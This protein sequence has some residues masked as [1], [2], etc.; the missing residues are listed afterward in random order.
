MKTSYASAIDQV[1]D[2]VSIIDR[3]YRYVFVND[4]LARFYDKPREHFL[5]R[6]VVDV[7]GRAH[8]HRSAK[9]KLDRCFA[10]ES[11]RGHIGQVD[12]DGAPRDFE[13]NLEPF[14]D[15]SGEIIGAISV[16]RDVTE[17]KKRHEELQL[18]RSAIDQI[19]ERVVIVDANQRVRLVNQSN[20][21]YHG[22]RADEVIGRHFSGL[23]GRDHYR[24]GP[25]EIL[26]QAIEEGR[27]ARHGYWR[28]DPDGEPRY[29]DTSV[30]PYREADDSISGAIATS[31][32]MTEHHQAER[33]RQRFQDAIEH[34][35]D[36]YALFDE[37]ERLAACNR[38][39]ERMH[40]PFMPDFGL[41]VSIETILRAR[42][43]GGTVVDAIGR[44][45]AWIAERLASF[46]SDAHFGE[47]RLTGGRWMH[48]RNRRTAD[49]GVLLMVID[50]T[51]SKRMA[52][53][54]AETRSRFKDFTELA[55][56]WFWER[57]A[58][59]RYTYVSESMATL[60][61]RPAGELLG[62][63]AIEA[64]G[65]DV[66]KDQACRDLWHELPVA[67]VDRTA[68]IEHDLQGADGEIHR[69]RSTIR[70]VRNAAD[71]II[72]YRGAAK[73]ITAAYQ[74]ERQLEHQAN[75]D[76]LTGLINRRAFERHLDWAIRRGATGRRL[77]VFCFI[78]LDQF[79]I[80]NDTAGHLAGDRLLRQ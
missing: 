49:G 43:A 14:R 12:C 33:T 51:D 35:A 13:F 7:L 70:P 59:G 10:G 34:L 77:S 55:A 4:A 64:L 78:D 42:V 32:D 16:L 65:P 76:A 23:I 53:A 40:E 52:A 25:D 29:W 60:T 57:D 15:R 45:A 21:R 3:R 80:V 69:V 41:G 19:S 68:E 8:F 30:V 31:R 2:R 37:N 47:F 27:S 11:L 48:V 6:R 66:L 67:G 75:H 58:T 38:H 44:E 74:L 26:K 46:R 1:I 79:K 72:G 20:L 56:D 28:P 73:D 36:G 61:G 17:A 71:A 9:E 5:G 22:R 24:N 54:L 62:R 39:Y 18:A 63:E 50:V